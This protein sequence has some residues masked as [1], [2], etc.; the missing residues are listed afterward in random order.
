M[1]QYLAFDFGGTFI[2]Y[3]LVDEE[4]T[5]SFENKIPTP[6][7]LQGLM[8]FIQQTVQQIKLKEDIQGLAISCPGTITATGD[9]QGTSAIP[10][11]HDLSLKETLQ[12]ITGEQV[13]I[14]NDANCAA[15]A[16]LWKGGAAGLQNVLVIVIGTGIGGAI[17]SNG[18]LY[19]GA[20]LYGGEFGYSILYADPETKDINHWSHMGSTSAIIRKVAKQKGV[21]TNQFSGEQIFAMAEDGDAICQQ[22]IDEFYFILATGIYNLQHIYDPEIILIGGGISTRLD[23]MSTLSTN[24][25]EIQEMMK[26]GNPHGKVATCTFLQRA[27]LIGATYHFIQTNH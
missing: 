21:P 6:E 7:S 8:N 20:H 22:A 16:E 5:I 4:A 12:E 9:V 25:H 26:I 19:R 10:Y 24:I 18:K 17:I 15:L 14:E 1:T 2:K 23:F 13:A 27:N 11:L 3:A